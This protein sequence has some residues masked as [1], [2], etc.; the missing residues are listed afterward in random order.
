MK[1][2]LK[3]ECA[4]RTIFDLATNSAGGRVKASGIA[5]RQ[6]ISRQLLVLILTD[7]K[8]GGFVSAR[9]GAEGGYSLAKPPNQITVGEVLIFFGEIVPAKRPAPGPFRDLWSRADASTLSIVDRITFADLAEQ[10]KN[11][12]KQYGAN[13]EI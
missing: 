12:R 11:E 8:N 2:S 6:S 1:I 4:L 7:L 3:S 9:R 13:W 5:T 10:W